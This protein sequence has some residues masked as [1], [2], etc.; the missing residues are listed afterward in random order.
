MS[1]SS[2]FTIA[3]LATSALALV[4]LA[5]TT[6]SADF[7]F[8]MNFDEN[9][10]C[11]WTSV[12]AGAGSCTGTLEAD[13][14]ATL[15][16]F[17]TDPSTHKVWVFPIPIGTAGSQ[18]GVQ[19]TVYSGQLSI[20]DPT[21]GLVSDRLRWIDPNGQFNT[22]FNPANGGTLGDTCA[23]RMILYS[24]DDIGAMIPLTSG[25]GSSITENPN[26]SFTFVTDGCPPTGAPPCNT[27]NGLSAPSSVPGPIV[28]A[29]LP[30]LLSGLYGLF[31]LNRKRRN[32]GA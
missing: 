14:S 5:P 21:T 15:P 23:T 4:S 12:T 13:P 30:G 19:A 24:A 20:L 1:K 3:L 22:C 25:V 8:T 32:R 28:G 6:A 17:I 26:G 31:W 29:G 18:N 16:G 7:L 10:N 9:G 2:K 11:T 27:Y